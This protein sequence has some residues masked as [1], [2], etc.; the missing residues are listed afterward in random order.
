MIAGRAGVAAMRH[1][2]IGAPLS[3]GSRPRVGRW[4]YIN[5]GLAMMFLNVVAFAPGIIDPSRRNVPLP[6]TPLVTAH[7][8]LGA[9]WLVLFLS[10]AT[11]IATRR[12]DLHRRAGIA[13]V[14]LAMAFVVV[15]GFAVVE[16]ARRGFDL[17]GDIGRLAPPG[18]PPDPAATLSILSFFLS[19]AVLVGLGFWY[20]NRPAVHKRLMLLALIGA[21]TPTPL[22]HLVGHWPSLQARA[23]LVVLV[24]LVVTLSA[25]A[26]YDR[27]SEGRIHPVSLW[28]PVL[29]VAWQG[30]VNIV[31][32]PSTAWRR[33]AMW[34]VGQ[35]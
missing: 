16:Q 15:G 8:T 3:T 17:S 9:A 2:T 27:I 28:V 5:A 11:L 21:L 35:A 1:Q 30:V 22:A 18:T 34:V 10:Q 13:G 26:I 29:L 19:F 6:L 24:A 33:V 25:S 14:L 12:V 23:G 31:V 32:V 4:F 20:R 7:A